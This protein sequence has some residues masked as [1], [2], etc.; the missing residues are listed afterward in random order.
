MP[1][2]LLKT[3]I[4]APIEVCFDAA[5]NIDLHVGSTSKTKERAIA[6]VTNG[7]IALG[8]PVTWEAIHFGIK[9]RLTTR[10][11]EFN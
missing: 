2:I 4:D 5:R 11:S 8:E 9:Q 3:L 10:I 7:L 1:V 6:G